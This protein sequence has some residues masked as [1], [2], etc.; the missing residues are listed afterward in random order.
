MELLALALARLSS[1]CCSQGNWEMGSES[2]KG[3][4]FSLALCHSTFYINHL[5]VNKHSGEG[6]EHKAFSIAGQSGEGMKWRQQRLDL[7][8]GIKAE[9]LAPC[10]GI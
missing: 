2:V 1:G 7:G 3:S 4:S 9:N 8:S 10:L 5:F 6:R